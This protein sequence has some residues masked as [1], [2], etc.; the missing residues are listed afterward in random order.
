MT[1]LRN[2]YALTFSGLSDG[3]HSFEYVL[4]KD[5]MQFFQ[6]EDMFFDPDV[7]VMVRLLKAEN[8]MKLF[9]DF[10]GDALT[11]C[12]RCLQETAYDVDFQEEIVVKLVDSKHMEES[13]DERLW[14]VLED[15][16]HI[17]L[18]PYFHEVLVLSRPMQVVCPLNED[19]TSGCDP[20]MED[21]FKTKGSAGTEGESGEVDIDPRWAALKDLKDRMPD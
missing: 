7:K 1:K 15:S 8:M 11:R 18:L 19:G 5:F 14:M 12:D 6:D 2:S 3:E 9:F 20:E 4:D 13:D 17:D 16:V 21:F 10:Q